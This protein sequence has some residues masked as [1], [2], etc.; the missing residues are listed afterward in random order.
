ICMYFGVSSDYL[1]CEDY[2]PDVESAATQ[3]QLDEKQAGRARRK[4]FH[5]S[6]MISYVLAALLVAIVGAFAGMIHPLL[7]IGSFLF[8]AAFNMILWLC[9]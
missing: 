1:I 5:F 4:F 3:P 2:Q 6:L 8:L 7:L 9:L